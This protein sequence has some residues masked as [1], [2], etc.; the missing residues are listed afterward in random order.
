MQWWRSIGANLDNLIA[1]P[2]PQPMRANMQGA[3]SAA[4]G[5]D[6]VFHSQV[7]L[8]CLFE[9]HDVVV[10]VLGPADL[11]A[12]SLAYCTSSSVMEGLV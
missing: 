10:A 8:E 12:A 5:G 11:A 9:A 1:G 6:G 3:S 2:N 7:G 4:A